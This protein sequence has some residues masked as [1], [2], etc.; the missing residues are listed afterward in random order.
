VYSFKLSGPERTVVEPVER[1]EAVGFWR[2][3]GCF[4]LDH[5]VEAVDVEPDWVPGPPVEILGMVFRDLPPKL[6][7]RWFFC[8]RCGRFS[9]ALEFPRGL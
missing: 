1:R 5:P 3:V 9:P 2:R 4:F 8:R 7:V 6:P